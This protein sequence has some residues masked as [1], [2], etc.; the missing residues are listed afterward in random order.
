MAAGPTHISLYD[1]TYTPAYQTRVEVT[2][3]AGARSAAG[4]FAEQHY[5]EVVARLETAGYRR[6]EVSN[7]ALPGHECRHN[8]AYWHGEDYLGI[9]ASAV[10]TLGGERRTNPRSVGEYLAGR[11]A[12]IEVLSP[13]TKMW[14]KAMLGLLDSDG[15]D[16]EAVLPVVDRAFMTGFWPRVLERRYGK[17]LNQGFGRQQHGHWD[18]L[19]PPGES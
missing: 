18:S 15:V 7:F 10:S 2:L 4:A 16:E 17:F 5:A 8:L 14:E 9:G 13:E 19:V 1:L 6:Y 11:P 3:G 12:C